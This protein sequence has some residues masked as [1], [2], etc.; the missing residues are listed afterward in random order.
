MKKKNKM[1]QI[2]K[3]H[4]KHNK[5]RH[6]NQVVYLLQQKIYLN[7]QKKKIKIK[8]SKKIKINQKRKQKRKL[9]I[10]QKKKHQNLKEYL[11]LLNTYT[12]SI[13]KKKCKFLL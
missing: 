8:I 7:F 4:K 2:M 11:V 5:K 12:K 10:K 9:K 13:K 3:I 1:K 6:L